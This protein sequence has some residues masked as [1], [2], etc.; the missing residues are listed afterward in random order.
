MTKPRLFIA[1]AAILFLCLSLVSF[2]RADTFNGEFNLSLSAGESFMW[3]DISEAVN[4]TFTVITGSLEASAVMNC[5]DAGGQLVYTSTDA[6]S[7]LVASTSVDTSIKMNGISFSGASRP[8]SAGASY[9]VVWVYGAAP[10]AAPTSTSDTSGL[11]QLNLD[12]LWVFLYS[13][14]VLGFFQAYYLSAFG[15]IDLLYGVIC[16]LFLVPLYLRTK[17]LLLLCILWILLGGFFVAVMQAVSVFAV[18]FIAFGIAGLLYKLFRGGN[19]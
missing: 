12:W 8:Y 10:T 17:S 1:V 7:L 6:G 14:D 16:L 19:Q 9:T 11:P 5:T 3:Q 2:A 4:V 18:L 15:I 13:G